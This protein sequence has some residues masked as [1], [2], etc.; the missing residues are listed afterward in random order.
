MRSCEVR[1]DRYD[2][3]VQGLVGRVGDE[4]AVLRSSFSFFSSSF[5]VLGSSRHGHASGANHFEDAEGAQDLD[6]AVH[7]VF[8]AGDLDDHRVR[9][10]VHDPGAEDLHELHD[11]A[12]RD[13]RGRDLDHRQVTR[14][15]AARCQ[16]LDALHV[17]QF[18]EVGLDPLRR[19][20]RIHDQ[21]HPRH[22]R[23]IRVSH[24]QR[25]D[26]ERPPPEQRRDPIQHARRVI[27][28]YGKCRQHLSAP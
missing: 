17:D 10:D 28:V 5:F 3:V 2:A 1:R 26:V 7:L 14:H 6:E 25:D 12:A 22:S 18:V 13:R 20:V 23:P 15:G 21:R 9:C 11:F 16:N 4:H 27:H 19:N 8:A 24:G